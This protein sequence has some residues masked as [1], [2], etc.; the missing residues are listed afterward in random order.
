M[1]SLH[2]TDKPLML[3]SHVVL[4]PEY[5]GGLIFDQNSLSVIEISHPTLK[6]LSLVDG[7][8]SQREIVSNLVA[9][10]GYDPHALSDCIIR[11]LELD[12]L[13]EDSSEC[14][15]VTILSPLSNGG[16][17]ALSAPLG[18]SIE[19]TNKC[20]LQCRYCFQGE[21]RLDREPLS[22]SEVSAILEDIARM[23]VFT[24]F[25]GGGEPLLCPHFRQVAEL[26][27]DLGLAVGISSNGTL[28]DENTARW[29]AEKGLDRG[30]QISLDGSSPEV[31]DQLR[32]KGSFSRTLKGIRFLALAGVHPSIGVTVTQT[33]IHDVRNIVNFAMQENARHVHLM[34]LLPSGYAIEDY[35]AIQPGFDDLKALQDDLKN[36]SEEVGGQV[37]IDWGNWCYEAPFLGFSECDYSDVDKSFAGCPAGKTKAV[38]GC[39]G[40]VYGCDVL[41]KPDL[42]AGNVRNTTFSDI[43]KNSPVIQRWRERVAKN[44]QGK[45]SACEWLFACVGGCPAMAIH[46]GGTILDADPVCPH[47]GHANSL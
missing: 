23:K 18:I 1:Q 25:F 31:H 35:D 11:L 15:P 16:P 21:M 14:A 43:W 13:R 40:D 29:F 5:F 7:T 17:S 38:I 10:E 33:N 22:Q 30:L 8:L 46:Q 4:R 24:V 3:S 6:I 9:V 19:L 2:Y 45:C 26:A 28:I 41:K 44:I 36:I 39:F 12:I 20:N 32:G 34:C 37:T 27:N 47:D 42:S